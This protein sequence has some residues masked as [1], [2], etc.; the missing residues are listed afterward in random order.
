L[1]V[2]E[3]RWEGPGGSPCA[4]GMDGPHYQVPSEGNMLMAAPLEPPCTSELLGEGGVRLNESTAYEAQKFYDAITVQRDKLRDECKRAA[5]A[6]EN[7]KRSGILA[8]SL[9]ASD[10]VSGLW[11]AGGLERERT[12]LE[13]NKRLRQRLE[14]EHASRVGAE[15]RLARLEQALLGRCLEEA[16]AQDTP[17][18]RTAETEHAPRQGTDCPLSQFDDI[19]GLELAARPDTVGASGSPQVAVTSA[20]R[21]NDSSLG[22]SVCGI[23]VDSKMAGFIGHA[24]TTMSPRHEFQALR[25]ELAQSRVERRIFEE[26]ARRATEDLA[27]A[28]AQAQAAHAV[29]QPLSQGVLSAPLPWSQREELAIAPEGCHPVPIELGAVAMDSCLLMDSC[30]TLE[31]DYQLNEF[32]MIDGPMQ[33]RGECFLPS[34]MPALTDSVGSLDRISAVRTLEPCFPDKRFASQV[35]GL[36]GHLPAVHGPSAMERGSAIIRGGGATASASSPAF[37]M[38]SGAVIASI[39]FFPHR[40]GEGGRFDQIQAILERAEMGRELAAAATASRQTRSHVVGTISTRPLS[41]TRR[42]LSPIRMHTVSGDGSMTVP[43]ML[44]PGQAVAAPPS[45]LR[46]ATSVPE[47]DVKAVLSIPAASSGQP[48]PRLQTPA[49]SVSP[50]HP[51]RFRATSPIPSFRAPLQTSTRRVR[52][53][54]GS[55]T[56]GARTSFTTSEAVSMCRGN[57]SAAALGT[58]VPTPSPLASYATSPFTSSSTVPTAASLGTT[59]MLS[60]RRGVGS[61]CTQGGIGSPPAPSILVPGTM[62]MPGASLPSGAPLQI[63]SRTSVRAMSP[64]ITAVRA[65]AGISEHQ[66]VFGPGARA[67]RPNAAMLP[68]TQNP[69][70]GAVV[71]EASPLLSPPAGVGDRTFFRAISFDEDASMRKQTHT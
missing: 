3:A 49:R 50:S 46:C 68:K 14:A 64:Q 32:G 28:H 51:R 55:I 4:W 24:A 15:N 38:T 13:E 71:R 54:E 67:A 57:Q 11:D 9:G 61:R 33:Q 70:R 62:P 17:T 69:A 25:S 31:P 20:A 65:P 5:E 7:S 56:I 10:D 58:Q 35:G 59:P 19:H 18:T 36:H 30:R 6:L 22:G 40:V 52:P 48:A 1:P 39:P 47:L 53:S 2:R 16:E 23:G 60:P 41:P 29:F 37:S 26:V 42:E 12:L 63:P 27:E 44:H 8:A 34:G 66:S 45:L 43:H 21:M